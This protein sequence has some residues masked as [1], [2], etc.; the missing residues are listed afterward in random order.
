MRSG[1]GYGKGRF[2]VTH[3]GQ[4]GHTS[5]TYLPFPC[6]PPYHLPSYHILEL[7]FDFSGTPGGPLALIWMHDIW[8]D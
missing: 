8:T 1:A 6:F 5:W 3:A 7:G 2:F 4:Y